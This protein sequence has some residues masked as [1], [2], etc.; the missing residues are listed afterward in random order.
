MLTLESLTASSE[1]KEWTA[2]IKS[3]D[4]EKIAEQLQVPRDLLQKAKA[5]GEQLAI[6]LEPVAVELADRLLLDDPISIKGANKL[7]SDF[8]QWVQEVEKILCSELSGPVVQR[9]FKR[10]RYA[11]VSSCPDSI[12]SCSQYVRSAAERRVEYRLRCYNNILVSWPNG[13]H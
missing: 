10:L 11:C 6:R 12:Q 7:L 9:A 3:G 1:L 13:R 4:R 2:A 5:R 8:L